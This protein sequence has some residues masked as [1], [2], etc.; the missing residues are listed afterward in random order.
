MPGLSDSAFGGTII[1]LCE[2]SA[3]GA[4]GLVINRASELTL[5]ELLAQLGMSP[6]AVTVDIPVMDGGPV[7]R[8]RG[9]ILHSADCH[10]DASLDLGAGLVLTTSRE[11]LEA[12]AAGQ[13]PEQFLVALGFAGWGP[14]QLEQELME[15]AWL[16][17]PAEPAVLFDTP[18]DER[19]VRAAASLGIDFN[20]LSGQAGHA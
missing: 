6:R 9:F 18:F 11:A 14:G 2:H 15:N 17:C 3:D 8:D 10:Y 7:A 20:L 16:N 4:M 19:V 5:V 1:Y 12:I 13:G